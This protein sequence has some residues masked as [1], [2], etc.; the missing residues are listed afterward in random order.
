[1]KK[2]I[3]L[4]NSLESGG[5][6]RVVKEISS[7][8]SNEFKVIIYTLKE[9]KFYKIDKNVEVKTLLNVKTNKQMFLK[10]LLYI[11]KLKKIIK[12]ENP[13]KIISFLELSNFINILSNKNAIISFR[14]TYD[15][16]SKMKGSIYK[17]LIKLLYP[18]A[19]KIIVNSKENKQN[20]LSHINYKE[21][22]IEVL[23]N[24]CNYDIVKKEKKQ[25]NNFISVGRLIETKNFNKMIK[26]FNNYSNKNQK[27]III[28]DGPE[29]ANLENLIKRL[30]A[31]N[32][33]LLGEKQNV[34]DYLKKSDCFLYASSYE[35]F[36]N[37]LIEATYAK[38]PIITTNFKTGAMEVI[39]PNL[40][41]I[42]KYPYYGPNGV[43]LDNNFDLNEIN[44]K[45]LIQNQEGIERFN[46]EN[47]VNNFKAIIR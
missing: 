22:N 16:F 33:K 20:L 17:L 21:E 13:E 4:I 18:K 10:Y 37:V 28:G 15:F 3:F 41:K 23:Y 8:L 29:R 42:D 12:K 30:N 40:E 24:N 2:I 26:S 7:S 44:F 5:A 19:E 11:P 45:K 35:G 32:I 36:P 39:D 46:K 14:T 47:V 38:L 9:S 34:Y 25:F 31:K 6:E 43:I 27:L 1:M